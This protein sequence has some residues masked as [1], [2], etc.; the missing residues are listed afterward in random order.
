MKDLFKTRYKIVK[1]NYFETYDLF[2]KKWYYLCWHNISPTLG[3]DDKEQA[4]K[5]LQNWGAR[6]SKN[7]FTIEQQG[8]LNYDTQNG[9]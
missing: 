4:L 3:F 2:V 7:R 5:K 6:N 8:H 9:N 1:D